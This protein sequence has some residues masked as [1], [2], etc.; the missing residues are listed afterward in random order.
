M[1]NRQ[2]VHREADEREVAARLGDF[3]ASL[4]A[5]CSKSTGDLHAD[6]ETDEFEETTRRSRELAFYGLE[7]LEVCHEDYSAMFSNDTILTLISFTDAWSEERLKNTTYYHS[8]PQPFPWASPEVSE[9][10]T[11]VL[12]K[13]LSQ[14]FTIETLIVRTILQDYLRPLFSKSRPSAITASGRKAEFRDE[15]DTHRALRDEI[16]AKPWKYADHRAIAVFRWAVHKADVSTPSQDLLSQQ[17][18]S[19]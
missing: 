18:S 7:I 9:L 15:E 17:V 8:A 3:G 16:E 19:S 11:Q 2:K 12:E 13:Q 1:K 6:N 14:Y 4:I 10:A 5:P